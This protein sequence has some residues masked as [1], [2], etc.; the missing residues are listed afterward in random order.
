MVE[1]KAASLWR[2]R[3][4]GLLSTAGSTET[5]HPKSAFDSPQMQ[6]C[7]RWAG[8]CRPKRLS[9]FLGDLQVLAC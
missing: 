2:D 1:R 4:G 6:D 7:N 9:K 3:F 5:H 8:N